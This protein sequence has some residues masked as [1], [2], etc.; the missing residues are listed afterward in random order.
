[1]KDT[2]EGELPKPIA[3]LHKVHL[4]CNPIRKDRFLPFSGP[5]HKLVQ[6]HFLICH[7]RVKTCH[8]SRLFP[9]FVTGFY[10]QI[11]HSPIQQGI[12]ESALSVRHYRF[13]SFRQIPWCQNTIMIHQVKKRHRYSPGISPGKGRR[14][15]VRCMMA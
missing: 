2:H 7:Q 13:F 12:Q 4:N 8:N 15:G 1:M 5:V 3:P 11:A 14:C 9:F 6:N 10:R